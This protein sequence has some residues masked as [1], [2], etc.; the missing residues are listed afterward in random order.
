MTNPIYLDHAATTPV[1]GRVLAAML[2]YFSEDYG[3]PSSAHTF[4][5][6][7]EKAVEQA[8]RDVAAVLNCPMT[9]EPIP[10]EEI[11]NKR[12][13]IMG[14]KTGL[15]YVRKRVEDLK[16]TATE[17]QLSKILCDVKRIGEKKGRVSDDEFKTIVS[18]VLRG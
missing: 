12:H 3:N 10:P 18:A 7:A 5:R 6:R 9:Y 16:L 8:R 15:N 14:K 17:E 1:D 2:P 4:G 13:L 11:G